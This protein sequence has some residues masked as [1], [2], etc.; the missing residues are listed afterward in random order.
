MVGKD[1]A[2]V[3]KPRQH[4]L[5][6][7]EVRIGDV[8]LA[9]G[10]HG[11][12]ISARRGEIIGMWGLVGSGRTTFF[13]SLFGLIPQATGTVEIRGRRRPLPRSAR[14][15]IAA[16]IV[17]VPES[18]KAALVMGMDSISNYWLGRRPPGRF[19]VSSRQ[20]EAPAKRVSEFFGFNARRLRD[21]V[22]NLSG[23]NQQKVL[24]AKWAGRDPH[25][26]L[27]DE[28]TRG[29]DVGAKVE[30]LDSLRDLAADGATIIVTS[31]E[32]EEVL[33]ICDRLLVFSHGRVVHEVDMAEGETS[34]EEILKFGFGESKESA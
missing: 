17:M 27:I 32:L 26:F 11:I 20:E 16:G 18:R 30:V 8:S 13:R 23:G 31:S 5:G 28:P 9:G 21:Q 3:R 1:A 2:I 6:E 19:F 33:A 15:A 7:V 10:L 25:L 4:E 12:D 29:I 24:L 34:V 14:Q 22:R